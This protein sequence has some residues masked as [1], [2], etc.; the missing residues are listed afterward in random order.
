MTTKRRNVLLLLV[1]ALLILPHFL[2]DYYIH[3]LILTFFFAYFAQSWSILADAGQ[4][5]MGHSVFTGI[6]AYTC[7]LMFINWGLS[8]WIG[9]LIGMVL[10][11]AVG[12]FIGYLCFRYGV[13]ELYFILVT[14]AFSQVAV[15]FVVNVEALGGPNGISIPIAPGVWNLQFLNKASYYYLILLGL[16]G[17]MLLR[18]QINNRKLGHYFAAIRENEDAAQ[19]LGIH[20]MKYKLV[21]TAISAGVTALCG[22]FYIQYI[23]FVEPESFLGPNMALLTVICVI[24][25]GLGTHWGPTIGAAFLIPLGELMRIVLH[26]RFPALP[27]MINGLVLMGVIIFI[28]HGLTMLADRFRSD[29]ASES[30]T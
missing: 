6:G 27:L 25:G 17:I 18:Y 23:S 12:L 8:P 13:R 10:A 3:I 4:I 7:G 21:A 11:M 16:I 5:S 14:L 24:V 15:Y 28:P 1:L 2:P 26:G 9:M 29:K 19:A 22:G 30:V 20:L